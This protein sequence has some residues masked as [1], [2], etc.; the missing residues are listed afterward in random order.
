MSEYFDPGQTRA[1]L[2]A[3]NKKNKNKNKIENKLSEFKISWLKSELTGYDRRDSFLDLVEKYDFPLKFTADLVNNN[4]RDKNPKT[5]K[6]QQDG[7]SVWSTGRA[8]ELSALNCSTHFLFRNG[9]G[10]VFVG[11]MDHRFPVHAKLD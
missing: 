6:G 9:N 8:M 4:Q 10:F 7:E 3:S 5:Y 1:M 11:R 2:N